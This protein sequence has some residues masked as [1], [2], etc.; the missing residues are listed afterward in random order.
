[1]AKL[2]FRYGVVGSAKTLN[3]LAV[4]HN[5]R[6]QGKNVLLIKPAV[7]T[8]FGTR[9]IGTRA[10]L[11]ATADIVVPETGAF[12]LPQLVNTSCLLIDEAQF[13]PITA[14]ERFHKIAHDIDCAV[15]V[16]CY[17]LRTDFRLE[18]FPAAKRLMELAD[19]I[20][21]IKTT[22]TDCDR[23]AVFNLKLKDNHPVLDGPTVELGFEETYL[24]VCASC[25]SLRHTRYM[26]WKNSQNKL[27]TKG[28]VHDYA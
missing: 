22:C 27:L 6:Q 21:E 4:A 5:Y 23:K 2:Y 17:G 19:T 9:T 24:P 3:L 25:Y 8:R 13:M 11:N 26:D 15:P 28:K 18:L 10:G 16:I 7:D 1:M 20:E 12:D 14:I